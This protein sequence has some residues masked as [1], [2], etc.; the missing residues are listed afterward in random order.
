MVIALA[1]NFMLLSEGIP[2]IY[3]F[4]GV[5][6]TLLVSIPGI[7]M[8]LEHARI[9]TLDIQSAENLLQAR[10]QYWGGGSS[11]DISHYNIVLR[12]FSFLY[13]PLFIDAHSI[14]MVAASFENL[15]LLAISL[16][17]LLP[18]FIRFILK[19]RCLFTRF[20]ATY[21]VLGTTI[22]AVAT[23][24][25]GTAARHKQ[26]FIP[27]LLALFVLYLAKRREF[28]PVCAPAVC[29]IADELKSTS[30]VAKAVSISGSKG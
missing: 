4:L 30:Q 28:K 26:M 18:S 9:E 13:R 23:P 20:C 8:F 16:V 15:I 3:R 24:N 12:L 14:S 27:C 25:L 22:M 29:P 7:E 21:F 10:D 6:F 5:I 19:D 1:L 11:V 17:M 2:L